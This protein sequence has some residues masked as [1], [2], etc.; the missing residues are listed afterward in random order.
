MINPGVPYVST[1]QNEIFE[2][3][4]L[5]NQKEYL[6]KINPFIAAP[7]DDIEAG[8]YEGAEEESYITTI[9]DAYQLKTNAQH[10]AVEEVEFDSDDEDAI[11][12]AQQPYETIMQTGFADYLNH[13]STKFIARRSDI[14][15]S[16][17]LSVTLTPQGEEFEPAHFARIDSDDIWDYVMLRQEY[18]SFFIKSNLLSKNFKRYDESFDS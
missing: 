17:T 15:V 6:N 14:I 10:K 5:L 11:V 9:F 18:R 7:K 13:L 12:L 4:I 1:S 8:I 3:R 16:S 2:R